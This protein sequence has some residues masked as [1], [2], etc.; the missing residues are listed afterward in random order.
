MVIRAVSS[1]SP[2][3]NNFCILSVKRS[4]KGSFFKNKLLFSWNS[5]FV[6]RVSQLSN[7]SHRVQSLIK[8]I[9]KPHSVEAECFGCK[10][11]RESKI[12]K[13]YKLW[14]KDFDEWKKTLYFKPST[15]SI[16]E[17]HRLQP[18]A[19]PWRGLLVFYMCDLASCF[20]ENNLSPHPSPPLY[21][22]KVSAFI[23]QRILLFLLHRASST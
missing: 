6:L 18:H 23:L 11:K 15:S 12:R 10:K 8:S 17:L 5:S 19:L 20:I 13:F 16:A 22:N 1:V 14:Y 21:D 3:L 2:I 7:K 4:E 9:L